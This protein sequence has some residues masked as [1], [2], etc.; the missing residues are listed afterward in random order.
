[1]NLAFRLGSHLQISCY[2]HINIPN[3][4]DLSYV[5]LSDAKHLG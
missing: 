5:R 1:M 2:A 3:R 4:K